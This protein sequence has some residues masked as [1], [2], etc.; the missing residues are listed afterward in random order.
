MKAIL[1]LE[2]GTTYEGKSFGAPVEGGGELIFN[3]S[4]TGYQ[5]IITD[6]SYKGQ[7]VV[8]TY[9]LIGNYGVAPE[10]DES[11]GPQV[12][13]FVVRELSQIAS[14]YRA[15]MTLDEWLRR[16]NIPGIQGVD[17]R[18]LTRHLRIAGALRGVISTSDLDPRL[19]SGE[20]QRGPA[21]V[22]A[23][24]REGRDAQRGQA[25]VGEH[26]RR[27]GACEVRDTDA[28][29][30]R[31][32][33]RLRPQAQYRAATRPLRVRG[34]AR[35]GDDAARRRSAEAGASGDIPLQRS[36]RPGRRCPTASRRSRRC[37]RS[38]PCSG[39]ASGI[40]SWAARSAGRR[41]SSSSATTAPTSPCRSF[42]TGKVSITSQNHGF[43]VDPTTVDESRVRVTELNLNDRTVEGIEHEELP[44]FSVQYH[45]EAAP[46]P[47]DARGHF[48]RFRQMV[49]ERARG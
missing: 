38:I 18:A 5:E 20:G 1:V 25:L 31:G 11:G 42:R 8:M 46:G 9:P 35:A 41:S 24:P 44:A 21:D 2:D 16:Y 15:S 39:Y 4:M 36:G 37:C 34:D 13:G 29:V 19:R 32:G 40:S 28:A 49:A 10:D 6:P 22:G 45:P 30:S 43:A 14:N 7:I 23:R 3:T 33:H 47:H 48:A 27:A 26:L 17:T 12:E